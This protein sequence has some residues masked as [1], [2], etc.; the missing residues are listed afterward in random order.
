MCQKDDESLNLPEDSRMRKL[1]ADCKYQAYMNNQNTSFEHTLILGAKA[2][3]SFIYL[4][5]GAAV[6]M[7]AFCGNYIGSITMTSIMAMLFFSIGAGLGGCAFLFAHDAQGYF[8]FDRNQQGFEAKRTYKT[9]FCCSM[10]FF[11]LGIVV[12]AFAIMEMNLCRCN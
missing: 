12:S 6:A 2:V 8:S 10:G 5:G 11:F 9:L 7:L 4:N 3:S 1:P